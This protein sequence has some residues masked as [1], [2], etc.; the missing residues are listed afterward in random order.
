MTIDTTQRA[1]EIIEMSPLTGTSFY[2]VIDNRDIALALYSDVENI[3][4]YRMFNYDAGAIQLLRA[5][6]EIFVFMLEYHVDYDN[7]VITCD[8][9]TWSIYDAEGQHYSTGGNSIEDAEGLS[10]LLDEII[11][12]AE[13]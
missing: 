2:E 1:Q 4:D 6:G 11:S 12:W 10:V 5:D 3:T 13:K 8:G 9:Y 7:E